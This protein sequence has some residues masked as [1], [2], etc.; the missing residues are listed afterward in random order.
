VFFRYF[1]MIPHLIALSLLGI[2]AGVVLVISWFS[3]LFTGSVPAGMHNYLAGF[4]RWATRLS[5]YMLLLT[6][7]YP[8]FSMQ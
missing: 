7:E 3:A 1:M 2:G 8:P 5:A 4:L 6:D